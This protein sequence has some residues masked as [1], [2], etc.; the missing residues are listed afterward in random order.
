MVNI[1]WGSFIII[2]IGYSFFTGNIETINN[3]IISC[4]ST[5]LELIFDMVPL[6]V[7]WM[8]LM[9][10]AEQSGL[11]ECIAKLMTPVLSM[12]FPKIPKNHPA[13]GYVASNVAINLAGLG[14]AATPAG[15]KAMSKLQELN[16]DKSR[17]STSMITFLVLNTGGVTI[18]PTAILAL[19]LAYG[20]NNATVIVPLTIL[21]TLA[22]GI[23]GLTL[24]YFIRRKNGNR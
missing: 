1:I 5:A 9:R 23:S 2:G 11:I 19:R 17:A 20:S 8:G 14:S 3:E 16:H 13:L 18:I 4:G 6:L 15:L 10:I 12:L 22:A 7:I 21:A 24:D